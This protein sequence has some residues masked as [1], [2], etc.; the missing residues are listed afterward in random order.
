MQVTAGMRLLKD[1][2]LHLRDS[3]LVL[4]GFFIHVHTGKYVK[5][6]V[7]NSEVP[8]QSIRGW[9][10]AGFFAVRVTLI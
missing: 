3:K 6:L 7:I 4:L 1:E 8:N 10:V 5:S 2:V 9:I